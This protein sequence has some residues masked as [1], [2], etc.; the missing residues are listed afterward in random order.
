MYI[1][2]HFH[3]LCVN[4]LSLVSKYLHFHF[5]LFH[6]SF[7]SSNYP[8]STTL[9][10]HHQHFSSYSHHYHTPL[11]T[12]S[13][14]PIHTIHTS[15]TWVRE[16][17]VFNQTNIVTHVDFTHT[18]RWMLDGTNPPFSNTLPSVSFYNNCL[19]RNTDFIHLTLLSYQTISLYSTYRI[20]WSDMTRCW[21]EDG[22][23]CLWWNH[24]SGLVS[25]KWRVVLWLSLFL[26]LSHWVS[27]CMSWTE[28]LSD[29][30]FSEWFE[31]LW[32]SECEWIGKWDRGG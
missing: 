13:S 31:I 17:G 19:H 32:F 30:W 24:S 9:H 4:S 18:T 23:C 14:I 12:T 26:S 16:S 28:H 22:M 1:W 11:I 5:R 29:L 6:S 8:I 3:N 7:Y 21:S 10:S 25:M 15:I 20:D 27:V 2:A